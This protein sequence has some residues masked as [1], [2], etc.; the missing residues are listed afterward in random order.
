MPQT[1]RRFVG[2]GFLVLTL[3]AMLLH[4]FSGAGAQTTETEFSIYGSLPS[5]PRIDSVSPNP[6]ARSGLVRITGANFGSQSDGRLTIDGRPSQFVAHWSD[7]LIVAYVPED[8]A[9][10]NVTASVT[11]GGGT[12]TAGLNVT[13]R[14]SDGRI[15]WRFTVAGDYVPRRAAIGPD[16]TVYFNDERG[17]LYALTPDGG[18]KWVFQAG[19]V[20]AR[21]PVSVGADG[22]VY[23]AGLVP[24]D[25]ATPCEADQ[26]LVNVEGIFAVRPDGTQ[27]WLYD[28]TCSNLL[29][30]PNV[31]PDGK[32]HAVTNIGIGAFALNPDGT[33]AHA[34]TG[35]FGVDGDHGTEIVFGPASPGEAATRKY[36][37]Y[38]S[39]GLFGY[40]LQGQRVFLHATNAVGI[41]QPV[42]GQRTGTVYTTP[43]QQT[44][45]RLFA[46]SPQGALRWTSPIRPISSLS[47]P[48]AP[49][50]ESAVY[51]VQDGFKLHRVSPGDGSVIWS[52]VDNNEQLFDPVASPDDRLI[53]LGGRVA[54]GQP[55]FFEAVSS[56]GSRLWKQHLP[57]EPGLH[58]YGQVLPSNRARF[59][60]DGQTAY[61]A[62][63]ILGD[64]RENVYSY[65]YALD[66]SDGSAPINHPPKVT[67]TSPAHN[68][69]VAMGTRLD[70][71]ASVQDDGGIDRVEFFY[72]TTTGTLTL[73]GAVTSADADGLYGVQFTPTTPGSHSF[74]A[75]AYDAAGLSG[76]PES[77]ANIWVTDR[78]PTVSWV[79]PTDGSGFAAPGSITLVARAADPDGTVTGVEF[80]SYQTGV[81]GYNVI[82]SDTTPDADGNYQIVWA[83]PPQGTYEI[84]ATAADNSGL[85]RGA[86]ITV[87][88]GPASLPKYAIGGTVRDPGGSPLSGVNVT[89]GNS[90]SAATTTGADGSYQFSDLQ[91]GGSYTVTAS[92]AGYSFSPSQHV[93]SGLGSNQTANFTGT[94]DTHVISGQIKDNNNVGLTEVALTVSDGQTT[95]TFYT[96]T[97][98]N[99]SLRLP[100]GGNYTVT[101]TLVNYTFAPVSQSFN[102]L[103]AAQTANFTGTR[104]T[105]GISGRVLANGITLR[106]VT[107]TLT[108]SQTG[109]ATT[110]PSGYFSFNLPAGGTYTVTPSHDGYAFTPASLTFSGLSG[111]VTGSF[112]ATSTNQPPRVTLTGPANGATFAAPATLTVSADSSDPD[113]TISKVEFF[114]Q[115]KSGPFHF[116]TISL[117]S[118]TTAPYSATFTYSGA[119][120]FD[121]RA[122][123]T[124]D[125]GTWTPSE[126]VAVTFTL[127]EASQTPGWQKQFAATRPGINGAPFETLGFSAVD[128]RHA[129]ASHINAKVSRTTDGGLTWDTVEM[130]IGGG[131]NNHAQDVDFIDTQTGWVVGGVDNAVLRST[132]GGRTY[133]RQPTGLS[134]SLFGVEALDVNTAFAVGHGQTERDGPG[135][136]VLRTRDGGAT[137]DEMAHPFRYHTRASFS[138]VYFIN[139]TTGWVVGVRG[140][141]IKTT[142]GGSTWTDVSAPT[143]LPLNDV[144]F[145][146]VNNGWVVG[147]GGVIF[148]TTDG[149]A[150]WQQQNVGTGNAIL[151]VSAVSPTVALIAC[152][153]TPGFVARTLDGGVTWHREYPDAAPNGNPGGVSSYSAVLFFNAESG[154]AAGYSGIYR[155]GTVATEPPATYSLS[156]RVADGANAGLAGV[157]VTLSGAQSA[158]TQTDAQGNYSFATLAAGG[159]YAVT[160]SLG[161]Y[162]FAPSSRTLSNFSRD[163]A[164]DFNASPVIASTPTPTPVPSPTPA[165]TPVEINDS[166]DFVAQHYRDFLG[167]EADPAGLAHW[168]NEIESCGVDARCREVRR[169]NVSAAFFLSIEFQQTGYLSFRARKV[170]F[171]DAPGEPVPVSRAEMLQ[172]MQVVASG[173]VVGTENWEQRLEQN[174]R[175]YFDRLAASARFTA[176]YP[177][178]LSPEAYVDAL[179]QN[180]GGA[181]SQAERDALVSELRS[182]T[183]TRAQALRAVA[184]DADLA[185]AEFN[186]A[187]VL[188]QFFGYL[189]R[190]P[191]SA[192]DKDFS[193]YNFWL[194]KL[195]SFN[196]N[197]IQA[198]MVKAFLESIEYRKRFGQ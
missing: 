70:I 74:V 105:H 165:P 138:A 113:G 99:Y 175:D 80:K 92:K 36:F 102:N 183:K 13:T 110:D 122:V 189:R 176:L 177:Q 46:V 76:R 97:N 98:G 120:L 126:P 188:M 192:P 137:W 11:A 38:E 7:T 114:A 50:S 144:S 141:V 14:P 190:D 139:Q 71:K 23:A 31:G 89:L 19:L 170:A 67:M 151:S 79:A 1:P 29:S 136:V 64:G 40:T 128:E 69:E 140:T 39:G 78:P 174:K 197:F 28:K 53:L 168:T 108:G 6:A 106:G 83:N 150:T 5:A 155:R 196:G 57:D 104:N 44:A 130:Q 181:L 186:K 153:G 86:V 123:A 55:G 182:N 184:E 8:S 180:A 94:R 125:R 121:L 37:Q 159:T 34:P 22:T 58:P 172:D 85:S 62:A 111:N 119:D 77:S 103:S 27:K 91:G 198:E 52:F 65:F 93:F 154:W 43:D 112:S 161:G 3:A 191:D 88:I 158:E 20:G 24:R 66:T 16:G 2:L 54:M 63:D 131:N 59:T 68:A 117:G 41:T 152:Y 100:A 142:N 187:F 157:T 61:I 75:V 146:D 10:G 164:A 42:A 12:G 185:R 166:A 132:D 51:V 82:G 45:G 116:Q 107:I 56:D 17:R 73:I 195:D 30:G 48:D 109:T 101:P 115:Y 32:I 81:V 193:G 95:T 149:G 160:P 35:R 15:R 156:G 90:V 167:R 49:P 145:A 4:N 134:A 60:A 96:S 162:T 173:V 133:A 72:G 18:L 178:A 129:W 26:Y 171:G 25:P 148:R 124:D 135:P 33:L 143:T 127:G 163:E 47:I 147:H 194:S 84:T 87:T 118:D 169:I 21:T 9:L 179:N